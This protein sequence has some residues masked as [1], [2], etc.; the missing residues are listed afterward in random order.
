MRWGPTGARPPPGACCARCARS[1]ARPRR[2]RPRPPRRREGRG[3]T[4]GRLARPPPARGTSR[5]GLLRK[6]RPALRSSKGEERCEQRVSREVACRASRLPAVAPSVDLTW[7]WSAAV[8]ALRLV[9]SFQYTGRPG[10]DGA[11]D[12]ARLA[13]RFGL[14]L[15]DAAGPGGTAS[16]ID[17]SCGGVMRHHATDSTRTAGAA[18]LRAACAPGGAGLAQCGCGT[19]CLSGMLSGVGHSRQRVAACE[20]TA[21][22]NFGADTPV[23]GTHDPS[24]T[25][26][27]RCGAICARRAP[28][29]RAGS[30]GP[31]PRPA[32]GARA[33][34]SRAPRRRA[35]A[36]G[37]A[38][39]PAGPRAGAAAP[40]PC[41]APRP[42]APARHRSVRPRALPATG[43]AHSSRLLPHEERASHA[44][45]GS[46]ACP[47]G[48]PSARGLKHG[49]RRL[50]QCHLMKTL[51]VPALPATHRQPAPGARRAPPGPHARAAPPAG[52]RAARARTPLR[53]VRRPGGRAAAGT[54]AAGC[55]R[56]RR[57]SQHLS[58]ARSSTLAR[59]PRGPPPGCRYQHMP[60][61]MKLTGSACS[62]WVDGHPRA[63]PGI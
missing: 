44:A 62:F 3:L 60:D 9:V 23:H 56:A 33:G 25:A 1:R 31:P 48:G 61:S 4:Q 51:E 5:A 52:A 57:G 15:Q 45:Q 39:A 21:V 32:A 18:A 14:A 42:P 7:M 55:A 12:S 58:A 59:R 35:A 28:G 8:E 11:L 26:A 54:G 16:V 19:C 43:A 34:R 38:C 53:L 50:S 13:C 24:S 22:H 41:A 36:P 63:V 2:S 49:R 46:G 40:A 37:A 20:I 6:R 27:R 29:A 17:W 47:G 10:N 30:C